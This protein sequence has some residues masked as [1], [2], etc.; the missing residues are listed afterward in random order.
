MVRIIDAIT[1]IHLEEIRGPFIEYERFLSVDLFFQD[2]EN[3]LAALPGKYAAPKGALLL[4]VNGSEVM[5]CV[6]LRE[7]ENR[8]YKSVG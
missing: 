4:A 8:A 2:F 3:E 7:L 6:A 1:A 5:G